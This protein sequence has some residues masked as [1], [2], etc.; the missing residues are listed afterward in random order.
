MAMTRIQYLLNRLAGEAAE[1]SHIA[2]KTQEF[3]VHE[4]YQKD[5][6]ITRVNFEFNDVLAVV[7]EI[8]LELGYSAVAID[9]KLIYAKRQKIAK[10][11]QFSIDQGMTEGEQD[12]RG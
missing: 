8:N 3:G 9:A 7:A 12:V 6:N 2:L 5:S 11:H 4:V 10:Y 1:L